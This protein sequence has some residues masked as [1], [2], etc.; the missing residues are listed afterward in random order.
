MASATGI[1]RRTADAGLARSESHETEESVADRG[2]EENPVNEVQEAAE[3]GDEAAGIFLTEAPLD[4]RLRDV[5]ALSDDLNTSEALAAVF[6]LVSAIN[7]ADPDLD[8][9]TA[10]AAAFARYE[11]VLGVYGTE[12]AEVDIPADLLAKAEARQAARRAKDFDEA[13]RLRDE[14]AAA[15]FRVVDTAEGPRLERN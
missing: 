8:S 10:A 4:E 2:G 9:A 3:F 1:F 7:K 13:D 6:A 12:L 11:D 5:A 14:I 15:G